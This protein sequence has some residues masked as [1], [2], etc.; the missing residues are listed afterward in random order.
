MGGP[1]TRSLSPETATA[2]R[3][4]L[5]SRG[6]VLQRNPKNRYI[7]FE[8]RTDGRSIFTLYTSRKLVSTV[9]A[10]DAEGQVL[11]AEIAR[12]AG[13]AAGV[14][15]DAVAD[16]APARP[17]RAG[18]RHRGTRTGLRFLAGAD[19][20]GTG[21]L[22]G[23][24]FVA[25]ALLPAG[26]A[27]TVST[28]A[29][30]V[31]TKVS[32]AASGWEA[33][34]E[35]L[36]GLHGD[37]LLTAVLPIP[38]RLFDAY[39]KNGL[40]D[41]TYVRLAGDLLAAAGLSRAPSL[42]DLELVIDDYGGGALLDR[43]ITAW[44]G[45]GAHVLL[46][47]KA[48]ENHI[49]AR[50]ASVVARSHR[51][52]EMAGLQASVTDG[53]LGTGNAGHPQT[54]AWLR[55]RQR[56]RSGWPSFV[57]ASFKT[58]RALDG[59]PEVRKERVPPLPELLDEDAAEDLLRGRLDVATA[60][61]RGPGATLLRRLKVNAHGE[62]LEPRTSC[63][64]WDFLPLLCGGLV[65]DESVSAPDMLDALLEPERGLLCGWRVLVGPPG[66]AQD[67]GPALVTLARA[68][69]AGTITVLG[70]DQ[71]DSSE[72]CVQHA[73]VL[74]TRSPRSEVLA[75]QLA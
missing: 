65:L 75:L 47:T 63:L 72:R 51:S 25:G 54:L 59:L 6:H 20:T 9:R 15:G 34:G 4:L 61:L 28:V 66:A 46:Q 2:L 64:A 40:L 49:A 11:E 12:L 44:R 53:P 43:A 21:E 68:H 7:D 69:R 36:A 27:E 39:S 67:D 50:V 58:V 73:G 5:A 19:E 18:P 45:A 31:D 57:K 56:A 38:N 62:L 70:T 30:H 8:V 1:V 26:L 60:R 33:L 32:R 35:R 14:T 24:A 71:R 10:G 3:A 23:S 17:A 29:G 55:R 37:G 74:L 42:E 13:D 41:L 52:R 22:L 16:G 48:D